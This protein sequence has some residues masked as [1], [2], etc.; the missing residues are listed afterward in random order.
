[1][2]EKPGV[3]S[4]AANE[5]ILAPFSKQTE[6]LHSPLGIERLAAFHW[7]LSL[8]VFSM[9]YPD[10][11]ADCRPNSNNY[12]SHRYLHITA[13]ICGLTVTA[14]IHT[15]TFFFLFF[16]FLHSTQAQLAFI[17]TFI[18][19]HISHWRVE[20]ACWAHILLSDTI[21]FAWPSGLHMTSRWPIGNR[22]D[23][24]LAAAI[25]GSSHPSLINNY[26]P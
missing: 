17:C 25:I 26:R 24:H 20:R 22:E 4:T 19:S 7:S 15:F 21:I 3:G 9:A 18:H 14:T 12:K 2:L 5:S 6:S 11:A 1:M 8:A 10:P 16:T 13:K 23:S